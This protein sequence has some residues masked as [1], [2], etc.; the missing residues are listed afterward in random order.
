MGARLNPRWDAAFARRR[1]ERLG[2][3]L[4]QRAGRLSGGERA[5]LALTLGLAKRPELRIL[6][7]PVAAVDPLA[8]REFLQDLMEVVAEHG[9]S[10]L[11]SSHLV[12]DLERICDHLVVLVGSRLRLAG[13]VENLLASHHRLVGPRC[14]TRLPAAQ[15][16]VAESHTDR[17]TTLIV[18]TD[19]PIIDP[20]WTVSGLTLEDLV[21]A[22]LSHPPE[23]RACTGPAPASSRPSLTLVR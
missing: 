23:P 4:R 1:V 12:T 10:V 20:A 16:V 6:D 3:D 8:R 14:T 22:H 18:R 9:L 5:Q 13:D 11:L 15:Q 7:E 2:L 21:L 17:Q 19:E